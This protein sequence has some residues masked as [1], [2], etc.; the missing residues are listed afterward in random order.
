MTDSDDD[1][2]QSKSWQLYMIRCRDRS[3]YTGITVDVKRRLL[4][5]EDKTGMG[6]G[7]KFLR[8]KGP[9]ELVFTASVPCRSRAL[10]LEHKIK[11]LSKA[12]K[13]ALVNGLIDVES[14]IKQVQAQ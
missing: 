2:P 9:L 14:L 4:E 13:E 7:A 6:K 5:H 8:G 3:L 12:N 11:K 1:I 10:K